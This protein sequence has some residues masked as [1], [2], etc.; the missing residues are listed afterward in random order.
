VKRVRTRPT[1]EDD[2][3]RLRWLQLRDKGLTCPQ[4]A[5]ATGATAI[6]VQETLWAIDRDYRLS[7]GG[8]K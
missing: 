6:R 1:R 3:R 4:I 8:A 5:R 2:E 7:C